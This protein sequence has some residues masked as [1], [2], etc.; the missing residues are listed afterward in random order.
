M[1]FTDLRL[2]IIRFFRNYRVFILAFLLVWLIIFGINNMLKNRKPSDV[3][4]T[5]YDAHTSVMS[6]ESTVPK[7]LQNDYEKIIAEYVGYCNS[8]EFD[9]A[10]G[11]LSQD[12][13]DYQF[14]G[15]LETYMD[16]LRIKVPTP[17][18]YSI[19][20]YSNMVLNGKNLYAYQIKY[21]EDILSTGLSDKDYEFAEEKLIF[22]EDDYGQISLNAA[23]FIKHDELKRITENEYLKVDVISRNVNYE[24]EE[25]EIKFTNRSDYTI[26]ISDRTEENEVALDLTGEKRDREE[27][28]SIVL[29]P[30][31]SQTMICTFFRY[32]DDGDTSMSISL[33]NVRVMEHYS[34]ASED[35]P[36]ETIQ[37]EKN[38]AISKFGMTIQLY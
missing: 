5:S 36:K 3:P 4:E 35:I 33:N 27:I 16:Y 34:G 10:F 19:Q 32:A 30:N 22:T 8:G 18:E 38:N 23:G 9:K 12:C 7:S 37:S 2:R 11:M 15:S 24:Y 17:R 28:S 29:Q 6:S 21:Y 1:N 20:D 26:V 14:R 25:Y 31:S 13:R